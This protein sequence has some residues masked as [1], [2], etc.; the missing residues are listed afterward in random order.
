MLFII[1]ILCALMWYD[2]FYSKIICYCLSVSNWVSWEDPV[3]SRG[4][5]PGGCCQVKNNCFQAK[6]GVWEADPAGKTS[7]PVYACWCWWWWWLV[8]SARSCSQSV[9]YLFVFACV[10][11][12][13]GFLCSTLLPLDERIC[14]SHFMPECVCRWQCTFFLSP[15]PHDFF[16]IEAWGLNWRLETSFNVNPS[17][18]HPPQALSA[19][20]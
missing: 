12:C 16:L 19:T 11:F 15:Q 2:Y 4:E 13:K 8:C 6:T 7:L 1:Y 3:P 10:L 14:Q 9:R 17:P 5:S 18:A 20:A